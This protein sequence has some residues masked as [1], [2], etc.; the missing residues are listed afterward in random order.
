[1]SLVVAGWRNKQI[2]NGI[3]TSEATVKVHRTN[4]MRKPKGSKA[5]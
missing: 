4:L 5:L 1:M 2:A 3:Q